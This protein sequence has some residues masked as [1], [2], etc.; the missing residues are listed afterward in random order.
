MADFDQNDSW[1]LNDDAH[2][3]G[4]NIKKHN[5]KHGRKSKYASDSDSVRYILFLF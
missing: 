4:K 1:L 3:I 5:I 2:G